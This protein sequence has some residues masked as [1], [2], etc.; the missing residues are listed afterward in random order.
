MSAGVARRC[1]GNAIR[2][3]CVLSQIVKELFEGRTNIFPSIDMIPSDTDEFP[4]PVVTWSKREG[5]A[6]YFAPQPPP[7]WPH[8]GNPKQRNLRMHQEGH[9]SRTFA[10]RSCDFSDC[11][12]G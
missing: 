3:Y 4:S 2:S 9:Y 1:D 11:A 10:S 7:H 12:V 5:T 6:Q 8:Q